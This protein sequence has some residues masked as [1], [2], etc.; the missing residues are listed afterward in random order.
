MEQALHKSTE[1]MVVIQTMVN[2]LAVTNQEIFHLLRL[3]FIHHPGTVLCGCRGVCV[4]VW[5]DLYTCVLKVKIINW[6]ILLD[7][8]LLMFYG[9]ILISQLNIRA[10]I[11]ANVAFAPGGRG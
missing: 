4:C 7:R 10:E 9:H 1:C 8:P 6:C 11:L 3:Q 5:D 2:M